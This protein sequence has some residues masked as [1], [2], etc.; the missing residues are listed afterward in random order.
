MTA[1]H[2][3]ILS[4]IKSIR[5]SFPAASKVYTEGSCIQFAIILNTI[6]PK[7]VVLYDCNHAIF[8]YD[9]MTFD[10]NGIAKKEEGHIPIM[11]YGLVALNNLLKLE[12]ESGNVV[13]SAITSRYID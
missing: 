4:V 3:Q 8:E 1:E 2:I 5:E 10:I 9:N 7:G 13:S 12:Y 6:W 11:E